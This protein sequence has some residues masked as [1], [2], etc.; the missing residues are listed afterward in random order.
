MNLRVKIYGQKIKIAFVLS[1]FKVKMYVF[2]KNV[3]YK[4]IFKFELNYSTYVV[5][6]F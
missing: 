3:R 5:E 4:D 2:I 1:V 6:P